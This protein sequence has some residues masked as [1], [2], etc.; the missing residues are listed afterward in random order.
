MSPGQLPLEA[1]WV[2][3]PL[4][5]TFEGQT[6]TEMARAYWGAIEVSIT[7]PMAQLTRTDHHQGWAF[8]MKAHHCPEARF[9][10]CGKLTAT[11]LK[12]AESFLA[13]M[14][15]DWRAVA[16][17]LSAVDAECQRTQQKLNDLEGKFTAHR[18]PV[19]QKRLALQGTP[20][21]G[22]ISQRD[23]GLADLFDKL[24]EMQ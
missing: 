22:E 2:E 19:L 21:A 7:T 4:T 13:D 14:Y 11:G 20:R 17:R 24:D 8:A 9:A 5:I 12:T 1:D 23:D 16:L 3:R 18:R 15:L 10:F 6:V